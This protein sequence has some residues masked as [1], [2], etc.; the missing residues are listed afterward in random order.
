MV[1]DIDLMRMAE[2]AR[3]GAYAPY[4]DF[5]VGAAL[6]TKSGKVYTGCNIEN[7]SFGATNC[8]ERTAIFKA[9]SEGERQFSAIAVVGGKRQDP[10]HFAPPAASAVRSWRSFATAISAFCW[11]TVTSLRHT[12]L[13]PSFPCPLVGTICNKGGTDYANV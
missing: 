8:A 6:L 1:R 4:S 9:V 11:A 3:L 12:P 13:P 5:L 2:E 10:P 7:A